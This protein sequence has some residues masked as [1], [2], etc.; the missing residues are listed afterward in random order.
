MKSSSI[1]AALAAAILCV[2]TSAPGAWAAD[3]APEQ[4]RTF[5]TK[6]LELR[7]LVGRIT[8][9]GGEGAAFEVTV[10][11][12][13]KD[14]A[15]GVPELVVD[16]SGDLTELTLRFPESKRYVYPELG[17]NSS[18]SFDPADTEDSG[19]LGSLVRG[20]FGKRITVVGSGSGLEVWADVE[21][22][23]PRSGSL[24]VRH[25]VGFVD[26]KNVSGKVAVEIR[27][28]STEARKVSGE[29]QVESGSGGV[30]VEQIDGKLTLST[31]SGPVT[32]R[33]VRGSAADIS[34]GSGHVVLERVDSESLEVATGSG[35]VDAEGIG[36]GKAS[37]A[38]GSGSVS[39]AFVRMG[40][41]PFD[42][43][44][45]SGVVAL[46]VPRGASMD[47]HAE[48][49]S[50]GID[51][52]LAGDMKVTRREKD[53]VEFTVGA[54]DSHVHI[55]TGSGSIRIADAG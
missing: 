16:E 53:E 25:G 54:G 51:L 32:A 20:L 28:G 2:Q 22:R 24:V 27:A 33:D 49:G 34:T 11:P 43:A 45:G 17:S 23:V 35:G 31:G 5:D 39:F 3:K 40:T 4:R 13:G 18:A 48:T 1:R 12:G 30:E 41:G 6:R 7:N 10:K 8:V 44:T 14:A 46:V 26:A 21:I 37:V 36:A 15:S 50:G 42:V 29:L 47:V 38:T 9:T 55:G 19:W 52:D